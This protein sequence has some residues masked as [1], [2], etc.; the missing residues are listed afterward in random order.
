MKKIFAIGLLAIC[1]SGMLTG[2]GDKETKEARRQQEI[3]QRKAIAEARRKN[4]AE[5]EQA[6]NKTEKPDTDISKTTDTDPNETSVEKKTTDSVELSDS[7]K[8]AITEQIMSGEAD[9]L[10]LDAVAE[11]YSSAARSQPLE[12]AQP[13]VMDVKA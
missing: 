13:V 5:R 4:K 7:G 3:E 6:L 10:V 12:Q 1:L 8:A 11:V 9:K 2:C